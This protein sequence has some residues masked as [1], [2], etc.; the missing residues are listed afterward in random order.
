MINPPLANQASGKLV[1]ILFITVVYFA[2]FVMPS[3]AGDQ[4][5]IPLDL[6][7]AYTPE[8]AYALID[9]YSEQTRQTYIIGEMTKDLAFPIV[10]TL[11]MSL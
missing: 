2:I 8:Q 11:F 4:Q 1:F 3:L 9:T 7:F 6:L 10:Y 5:I